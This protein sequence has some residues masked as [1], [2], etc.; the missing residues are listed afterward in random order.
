MTSGGTVG[1]NRE[2]S[3]RDGI[4]DRSFGSLSAALVQSTGHPPPSPPSS[5]VSLDDGGYSSV[6]QPRGQYR[7]P[8][9]VGVG[10]GDDDDKVGASD[11]KASALATR[12][13]APYTA[14]DQK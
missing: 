11:R 6:S 2:E 10:F 8:A 4:A 7:W 5:V 1:G 9:P 13:P 3:I 12:Q 14:F